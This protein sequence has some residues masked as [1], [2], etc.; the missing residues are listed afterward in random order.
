MNKQK[1]DKLIDGEQSERSGCGV[2]VLQELSKKEKT[3]GHGQQCGDCI[4][5]G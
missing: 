2:G 4:G 3:H 1:R 5:E